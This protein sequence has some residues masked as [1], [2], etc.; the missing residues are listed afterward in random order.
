MGL[1]IDWMITEIDPEG[2]YY[3]KVFLQAILDTE[4]MEFFNIKSLQM[5]IEYLYV[6][7]KGELLRD[8]LRKF[9]LQA[10]LF[11]M[12][13]VTNELSFEKLLASN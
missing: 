10:V 3:G 9:M 8:V 4:N 13:F 7:F 12:I 2:N 1:R 6:R 5:I 11:Y